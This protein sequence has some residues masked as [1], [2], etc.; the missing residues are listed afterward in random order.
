MQCS[1]AFGVDHLPLPLA[2]LRINRRRKLEDGTEVE[3]P[4]QTKKPDTHS[5]SQ[6]L[7]QEQ[8][9]LKKRIK[10]C[11]PDAVVNQYFGID[12]MPDAP[13][14]L[15]FLT[16]DESPKQPKLSSLDLRVLDIQ[17]ELDEFIS[18]RA[19]TRSLQAI[20]A[21]IR[22]TRHVRDLSNLDSNE[23][24]KFVSTNLAPLFP[25]SNVKVL[26][27][28]LTEPHHSN[29][30]KDEAE[31]KLREMILMAQTKAHQ[32]LSSTT[33]ERN[34]FQKWIYQQTHYYRRKNAIEHNPLAF[35]QSMQELMAQAKGKI[36]KNYQLRMLYSRPSNRSE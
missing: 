33:Q 21:F 34:E 27:R 35:K 16:F 2:S 20:T 9:A 31:Q 26:A 13:F 25:D 36:E 14:Q 6:R 18:G 19:F 30:R 28:V 4:H 5:V 8:R 12:I 3:V 22:Q 7:F 15:D 10:D 17:D 29:Y 11:A 24:V 1:S 23:L 32:L